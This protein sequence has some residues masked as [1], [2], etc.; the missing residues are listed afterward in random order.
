VLI[1]HRVSQIRWADRILVLKNGELI[2]QGTHDELISQSAAYRRIFVRLEE[3][4]Q[5]ATT[6]A[7]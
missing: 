2:A 7:S 4:T 6:W 5:G 1:T 3:P